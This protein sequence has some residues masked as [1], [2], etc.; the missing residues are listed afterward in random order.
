[1]P[2]KRF[3]AEL[4]LKTSRESIK[5][6]AEGEMEIASGELLVTHE[7]SKPPKAFNLG[8]LPVGALTGTP[9]PDK[10]IGTVVNPFTQAKEY[11]FTRKVLFAGQRS[12]LIVKGRYRDDGHGG[13]V[14]LLHFLGDVPFRAKVVAVE[15]TTEIWLPGA[16]VGQISGAFTMSFRLEGGG[17][18]VAH[19]T[20]AYEVVE[21]PAASSFVNPHFRFITIQHACTDSVFK[22]EEQISLFQLPSGHVS[23]IKTLRRIL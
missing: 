18:L 17:R 23:Q 19:T 6:K 4:L 22:Q 16:K 12:P 11:R 21:S 20:T 5:G 14:G 7:Y 3:V 8:L 1:M 10:A 13:R 2:T 9:E 15:P